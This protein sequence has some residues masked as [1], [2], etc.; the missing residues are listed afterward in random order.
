MNSMSTYSVCH[1][2]HR[3]TLFMFGGLCNV[4][5]PDPSFLLGCGSCHFAKV[6]RFRN[7]PYFVVIPVPFYSDE[8]E[9]PHDNGD[10]DNGIPCS[11]ED[12]GYEDDYNNVVCDN[13]E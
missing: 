12:C 11:D 13:D 10:E 9:N 1:F 5:T 8:D 3:E 4:E 7:L 6:H 2:I